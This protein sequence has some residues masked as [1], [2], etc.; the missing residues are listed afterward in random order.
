MGAGCHWL[1]GPHHQQLRTFCSHQASASSQDSSVR[2]AS[3]ERQRL[4]SEASRLNQVLQ[5]KDHI[6]RW[7]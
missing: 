3:L 6:I 1:I 7:V 4:V 2:R 5:A